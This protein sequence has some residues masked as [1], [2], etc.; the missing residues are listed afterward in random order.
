[1]AAYTE[2]VIG[3]RP[4]IDRK[5]VRGILGH[6]PAKT[7]APPARARHRVDAFQGRRPKSI[8]EAAP[9]R[10]SR[11]VFRRSSADFGYA[12]RRSIRSERHGASHVQDAQAQVVPAALSIW[13]RAQFGW[14]D[15]LRRAQGDAFQAWGL[16]P[17]ECPYRIVAAGPH[18]RLRAY[19]D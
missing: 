11:P 10:R 14:N 9:R 12:D 13:S 6:R 4:I 1:R 5:C 19:A 16:G 18:W 17:N 7:L 2:S 15:V 3:A 8:S